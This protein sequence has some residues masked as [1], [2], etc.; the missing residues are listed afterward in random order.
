MVNL[1]THRVP[2]T[3]DTQPVQSLGFEYAILVFLNE[4]SR[5]VWS[6]PQSQKAS[7]S[8]TVIGQ[9]DRTSC[10]WNSITKTIFLHESLKSATNLRF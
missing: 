3:C 5:R 6:C 2:V 7:R 9:P 10:T 4:H 1:S 8:S